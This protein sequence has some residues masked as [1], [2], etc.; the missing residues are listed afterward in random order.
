MPVTTKIDLSQEIRDWQ[1]A[2][3]GE[4]VRSAQISALQKTQTHVNTAIDNIN[5][6]AENVAGAAADAAKVS[7]EAAATVTR[8]NETVD[9]ADGILRDA[10]AQAGAS[11]DSAKLSE[12]W[13][14]GGTGVRSGEGTD[15]SEYYSKQSQ[16]AAERATSEA[17]RAAQYSK[18]VAPGFY[19]DPATSG[20]YQKAGVG[21]D[22][23][24]VESRIYWKITA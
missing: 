8:A 17:D 11:A 13:T 6:A 14:R 16:T 21:V 9:H 19:F 4:E 23:K 3:Y 5:Q 12:S 20:L 7:R 22:F 2:E 24:V 18:I 1:D 10:T 15:N